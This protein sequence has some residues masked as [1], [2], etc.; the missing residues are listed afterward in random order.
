[1]KTKVIEMAKTMD[2]AIEDVNMKYAMETGAEIG[3]DIYTASLTLG[4]SMICIGDATVRA[5]G[6][7]VRTA[8]TGVKNAILTVKKYYDETAPTIIVRR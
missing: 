7:A 5:T 6:L 3:K 4:L 1:M 2:N 8:K